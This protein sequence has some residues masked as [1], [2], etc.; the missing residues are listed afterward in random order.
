MII[1]T[2]N[3]QGK[4]NQGESRWTSQVP[5]LLKNG[6]VLLLQ[7]C[8]AP[9]ADALLMDIPNTAWVGRRPVT[10][11]AMTFGVWRVGSSN[12]GADYYFFY[13]NWD[14]GSGRCNLAIIAADQPSALV[15]QANPLDETKR[16]MIGVVFV[17]TS[18]LTTLHAFSGSGND[19]PRFVDLMGAWAAAAGV[20]HWL[21][22]GDFNRNPTRWAGRVPA[23]VTPW[24]SGFATYPKSG[25]ELD[26]GF[27]SKGLGVRPV[28]LDTPQ[29]D[30]YPVRFEW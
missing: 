13:A 9:P 11:V 29:S 7:E 19:G 6:Q 4:S 15:F 28:T 1:Y 22:S 5:Q 3:M 10:D 30:H 18:L 14:E 12:R 8:G 20:P 26:Y 27:S 2:W 25:S 16:P 23:G 17:G 21:C 24:N